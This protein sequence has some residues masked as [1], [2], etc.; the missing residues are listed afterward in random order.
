MITMKNITVKILL[1]LCTC[2]HIFH[3]RKIAHPIFSYITYRKV[4][5]G[6]T[7]DKQHVE[8]YYREDYQE[9]PRR[10]YPTYREVDTR[11]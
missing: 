8:C 4:E 1:R 10:D 5:R 2:I 6:F 11:M 9:F 3:E 7:C